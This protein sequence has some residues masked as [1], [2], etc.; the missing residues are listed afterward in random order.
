[1]PE[2]DL[3]IKAKADG[4]D[5][6]AKDVEKLTSAEDRLQGQVGK[7]AKTQD[8]AVKSQEAL[9]ASQ[10]DW[11]GIL[12]NISPAL[13]QFA[14]SLIKA[15]KVSG[16]L[17]S[18]QIDL[19][20]VLSKVTKG[21]AAS[22]S[23]IALIGS[24][25]LVVAGIWAIT[26]A[27]EAQREEHNRNTEAI[28][29]ET[30]ALN[31]LSNAHRDQAQAIEDIADARRGGGFDAATARSARETAQRIK[32]GTPG[33]SEGS[34]NQAVGTLGDQ[35]LTQ[36]Q[37]AQAAFLIQSGRLELSGQAP[38]SANVEA[39]KGAA[40]RYSDAT[41][42]FFSREQAQKR[43]DLSA[44]AKQATATTG[45]S[46][47]L[48]QVIRDTLGPGADVER[49]RR[50]VRHVGNE[51]GFKAGS[52]HGLAGSAYD[53]FLHY[54]TGRTS[55]SGAD[56]G[57]FFSTLNLTD[58]EKSDTERVLKRLDDAAK[59]IEGG[60]NTTIYNQQ[61]ARF[62]GPS[63]ASQ[64]SRRTNGETAATRAER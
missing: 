57:S 64:R 55:V 15:A 60:G 23:A 9:N 53:S 25:G 29:A 37:L 10:E 19:G 31:D 44:A 14:G 24:G 40:G 42:R 50:I 4:F 11:L 43:E 51:S 8:D 6:A 18:R 52:E 41:S 58:T 56:G 62:I 17:A 20:S 2:Q 5:A 34:I 48:D 49:I 33:L 22:A 63:A 12:S 36:E 30:D 61:N 1:M 45:A 59:R 16:D 7:G 13:A 35:G 46:D 39:F 28:K 27:L 47:A 54:F 38:A 32:S 21:A 3:T 26:K